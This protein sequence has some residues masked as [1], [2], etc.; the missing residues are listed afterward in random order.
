MS[1]APYG[2]GMLLV[3]DTAPL[4]VAHS[5]TG[6]YLRDLHPTSL[7]HYANYGPELTRDFRGLRLCV[8]SHRSHASHVREALS[9]LTDVRREY[10]LACKAPVPGC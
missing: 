10:G 7:P 8:L 4:Q 2:T 9:V 6:E 5:A 3:R 1:Q